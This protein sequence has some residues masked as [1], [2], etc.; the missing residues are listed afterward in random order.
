MEYKLIHTDSYL[1]VVDDS[2]IKEGDWWV[3]NNP[4]SYYIDTRA[5]IESHRFA[6]NSNAVFS[7]PKKIIA[8]LP[9]NNS[10][11]LEGVDLLPPLEEHHK[12]QLLKAVLYSTD[13]K[14]VMDTLNNILKLPIAFECEMVDFKVEMRLGQE[15]IEYGKYLKTTTNSQ[16]QTVWVG[17]YK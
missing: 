10:P 13:R 14:T 12:D 7:N 16:G 4:N 8:H 2:E 17:T 1:L 3:N 15:C 5:N 11:I 9:L 6:N